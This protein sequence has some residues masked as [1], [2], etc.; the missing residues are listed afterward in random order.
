M[1]AIAFYAIDI[2]SEIKGGFYMKKVMVLGC[3]V[4]GSTIC[5]KLDEEAKRVL[6][7]SGAKTKGEMSN[8]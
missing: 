3:G 4:Q 8:E 2:K 7:A 5:R 1:E 6:K